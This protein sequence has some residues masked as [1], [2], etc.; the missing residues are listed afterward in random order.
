MYEKCIGGV[1]SAMAMRSIGAA[2][3]AQ[4]QL[5]R[6]S[7]FQIEQTNENMKI[8]FLFYKTMLL[9]LKEL[10][11]GHFCTTKILSY[12]SGCEDVFPERKK[13][14]WQK[15]GDYIFYL[16]M[17]RYLQTL[18]SFSVFSASSLHR[19][20]AAAEAPIVDFFT[21]IWISAGKTRKK[22][23]DVIIG[24]GEG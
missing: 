20:A 22:K 1:W 7:F 19:A 11:P 9:I 12:L 8:Y 10:E 3:E 4:T 2:L 24:R 23:R 13:S 17:K 15:T 16:L 14:S 5:R 6:H 18:K 21:K